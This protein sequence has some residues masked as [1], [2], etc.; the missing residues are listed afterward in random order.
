MVLQFKNMLLNLENSISK[1]CELA[2]EC[3]I[4]T[5]KGS[6]IAI[7]AIQIILIFALV[8]IGMASGALTATPD[9]SHIFLLN[10]TQFA[11]DANVTN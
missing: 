2:A 3:G 10:G 5:L 6:S 4:S 11:P 9:N 8:T 1:F 7:I